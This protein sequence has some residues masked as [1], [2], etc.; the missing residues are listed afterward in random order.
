M[1]RA[2]AV[3]AAIVAAVG[4]KKSETADCSERIEAH[5]KWLD[6][7]QDEGGGI[8]IYGVGRSP[9]KLASVPERTDFKISRQPVLVIEPYEF[10]LSGGLAGGPRDLATLSEK[11]VEARRHTG[12]VDDISLIVYRSVPWPTVVSVAMACSRAGFNTLTFAFETASS[13]EPPALAPDIAKLHAAAIADKSFDSKANPLFENTWSRCKDAGTVLER[14]RLVGSGDKSGDVVEAEWRGAMKACG[15]AFEDR[16]VRGYLWAAAGRVPD[17]RISTLAPIE[18]GAS[19]D[20]VA[21]P[22]SAKMSDAAAELVRRARAGK[23]V[24]L[25]VTR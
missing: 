22:Q 2:I 16:W 23:R 12:E 20:E 13:L 21:F 3:A 5:Q 19:G 9:I 10:R 11:L 7:L 15:C 1:S 24:R 17:N 6:A 25:S 18:V 8:E 4:C 14:A